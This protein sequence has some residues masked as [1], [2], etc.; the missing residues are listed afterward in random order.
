[1][2]EKRPNKRL[3][4]AIGTTHLLITT[5][6]WRDLKRRPPELVRGKKLVWRVAASVNTL[7]SV[8][9]LLFGRRSARAVAPAGD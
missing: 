5:L 4:L 6:T 3:L 7:G 9:Y 1:M 8:A 2:A